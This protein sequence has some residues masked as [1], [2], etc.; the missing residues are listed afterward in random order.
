MK[1][2]QGSPCYG[3]QT[4]NKTDWAITVSL[5][6]PALDLSLGKLPGWFLEGK[7]TLHYAWNQPEGS[8]SSVGIPQRPCQTQYSVPLPG[9][10]NKWGSS[11][12]QRHDPGED[13]THD[14]MILP[15][16]EVAHRFAD[17]HVALNGQD[18]QGPQGN[19]TC[20]AVSSCQS[21]S[22]DLTPE[23]TT[24]RRE[25]RLGCKLLV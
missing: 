1:D 13:H 2:V 25:D 22:S 14:G 19:F 17:H 20:K 6:S 15:E 18:H 12:S 5:F 10:A 9:P 7:T 23:R 8:V 11:T 21:S 4:W 24:T 3:S 16:A